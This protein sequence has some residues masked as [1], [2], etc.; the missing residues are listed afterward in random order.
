MPQ[1]AVGGRR[2]A[3]GLVG[4]VVLAAAARLLLQLAVMPSYAGLDELYHVAYLAFRA[5]EHRSPTSGERSV[6]LYLMG[7][8]A[9]WPD[10]L[11]AFGDTGKGWPQLVRE[12]RTIRVDRP[13]AAAEM[14]TYVV[15][16]YEAQQPALYY[17][18]AAPLVGL[19]PARTALRELLLWRGLSAL[20]AL[21][22]IIAVAVIGWRCAGRAGLL[23]ALLLVS[24]PTWLTLVVRASNDAA[25]C[26]LLA[27]ALAL[28]LSASRRRSIWLLEGVLWAAALATKL[29]AWPVLPAAVVAW[30]VQRAP[31]S[32]WVIVG[33]LAVVSI[34]VTA[35]ELASRTGNPLGL[36]AFQPAAA[37]HAMPQPIDYAG[38]LKVFIATL[39]WTSG[40]HFNALTPLG[41]ALYLL[42]LLLILSLSA[43]GLRR[44]P[45]LIAGTAI[46]AFALAQIVV[47][48][49]YIGL[50]RA[51]GEAM[52][53]GG[54]EG[55][56]WYALAPLLVGVVLS[57]SLREMQRRPPLLI[58][59]CLWIVAWDIALSEGALF[60]D[61][62]GLSDPFHSG[63]LVRW[64]PGALP[65]SS[66]VAAGLARTSLTSLVAA[67][68]VLR[69]IHVL[70]M[71]LI[72]LATFMNGSS[73]H[74][75]L[76]SE[77]LE[78]ARPRHDSLDCPPRAD[79]A[80]RL[81][82]DA[83]ALRPAHGA[84]A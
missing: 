38:M 81:L 74:G 45:L 56:Y 59:A 25:A 51:A 19:L 49:A 78:A 22:A 66:S 16:N 41:V 40:A 14:R 21:A 76:A 83:D 17:A 65:F 18:A 67:A 68:P 52:P 10:A 35:I 58:I 4:I 31:R 37:S 3:V 29:Y 62:A 69:L 46:A 7:S 34:A 24:L 70:G 82:R 50:A 5:Q 42:P 1:A 36:F 60:Q 75:T 77:P 44:Q 73:V 27:W 47:A 23:A 33:G 79:P 84:A 2:S 63:L 64:A 53:H 72:M 43:R 13:L 80:A 30:R 9:N 61:F 26:A 12:R 20:F 71:L 11:P 15:K 55:W 28:T 57:G 39:A 32:R 54:K 48:A 8:L 6:P